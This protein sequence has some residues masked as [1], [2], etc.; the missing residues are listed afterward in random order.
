MTA[1]DPELIEQAK[2]DKARRQAS[3]LQGRKRPRITF[4]VHSFNRVANIDQLVSGLRRI[5]GHELIVCDDGS[6]DGSREKWLSHLVQPNDFLILSNDLHE[7]RIFDRGIRFASAEIICLVQ[8]DDIIPP[9]TDWLDCVLEEFKKHPNLAIIG[10]FM[11]FYG[12]APDPENV[13]RIWGDAPFQFVDHVNIGPYFIRKQHYEA[14]GGWD[15]S[16]SCAGEPG[17]CFESELCLRAWVNGYQV[18]CRFVP[19]K[20][21]PQHYSLDG[22]TMLFSKKVRFRN[23]W[24]NRRK[25]F[26]KYS[27]QAA[28]ISE[29][30]REANRN[31]G[32]TADSCLEPYHLSIC[33]C[34]NSGS[35][36]GSSP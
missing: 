2:G 16:F 12:F 35:G 29:L 3:P 34:H 14:L 23:E 5:D 11:G 13:K 9:E 15:F 8:D 28:Q 19:F 21:P 32:L 36:A 22:G 7:I 1:V 18:G 30:V 27:G 26:Q 24:R 20:G 4:V 10:G 25:I 6:L 33:K 31:I 17:I